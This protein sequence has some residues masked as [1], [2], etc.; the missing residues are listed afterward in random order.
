[1]E[2]L[3]ATS[4][5]VFGFEPCDCKTGKPFLALTVAAQELSRRLQA[6]RWGSVLSRHATRLP[7]VRTLAT[8]RPV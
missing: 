6:A 1:V 2:V 4:F 8:S 7:A 5:R 3:A